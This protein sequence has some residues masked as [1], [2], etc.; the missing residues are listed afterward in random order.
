MWDAVRSLSRTD[1]DEPQYHLLARG[2]ELQ[3]VI[4]T[5]DVLNNIIR[6]GDWVLVASGKDVADIEHKKAKAFPP[7]EWR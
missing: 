7:V 4:A 3:T 2:K 5:P 1:A 6:D